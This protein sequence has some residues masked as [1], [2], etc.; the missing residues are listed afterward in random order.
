MTR[1]YHDLIGREALAAPAGSRHQAF[2][3]RGLL[4][5]TAGLI[6]APTLLPGSAQAQTAEITV[7]RARTEP[8]PI[9]IPNLVGVGGD[10]AQLGRDIAAVVTNNLARSGLFRAIDR[11]AFVAQGGGDVP[12]FANWKVIGA[13]ALVTGKVDSQG[14]D[15]K[16][17][18]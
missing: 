18:V 17:V 6:L 11:A 1:S 7:D 5:G 4:V 16:S 10:T 15:R 9:A 12:N 14:G 8:I 3:R 13:Q 2:G